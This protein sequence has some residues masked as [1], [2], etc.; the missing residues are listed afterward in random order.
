MT[1]KLYSVT[2]N[3]VLQGRYETEDAAV[4]FAD[5]NFDS[6]PPPCEIVVRKGPTPI[7]SLKKQ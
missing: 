1:E 4:K 2:V 3:D 5:Q 6:T 7:F